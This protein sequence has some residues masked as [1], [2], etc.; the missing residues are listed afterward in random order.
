MMMIYV[1]CWQ[2]VQSD[3][4]YAVQDLRSSGNQAKTGKTPFRKRVNNALY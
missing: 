2:A 3:G 4:G 1:K